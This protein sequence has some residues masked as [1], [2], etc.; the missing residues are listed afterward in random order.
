MAGQRFT[1]VNLVALSPSGS[2]AE[3]EVVLELLRNRYGEE[4]ASLFRVIPGGAG[5]WLEELV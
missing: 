5:C 2:P 3:S 1:R 4:L